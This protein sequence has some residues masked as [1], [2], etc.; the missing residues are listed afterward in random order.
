MQ[1]SRLVVIVMSV[2]AINSAFSHEQGVYNFLAPNKDVSLN[3]KDTAIAH[4]TE[5]NQQN[6]L[7]KRI[8]FASVDKPTLEI[9]NNSNWDLSQQQAISILVQNAMDW[10]VTLYVTITDIAGKQLQATV[11]LPAGPAQNLL[12]PLHSFSSRALGMREGLSSAWENNDHRYLL[13]TLVSGALASNKIKAISFS[14]D[15]PA[16][17]QYI[18]LGTVAAVNQDVERLAYTDI[19]DQYGQNTKLTWPEKVTTDE[20]L[21]QITAN[22][23]TQLK[24]TNEKS[25]LQDQYGGIGAKPQFK[26]THYFRTQKVGDHWYFVSPNGYIFYSFGVNTVIPDGSQ[27]YID[28]RDYMFASLPK[29]NSEL[30]KFYG[31]ANTSSGN[32]AQGGRGVDKGRWFDFY[33]AN[34]YRV[35]GNDYLQQ[36]MDSTV[37]RFKAWGFNTIG[38]WSNEALTQQH[39]LPYVASI[40]ITGDY[41]SVPSGM[42][43]WGFMP[44]TFDPKFVKA[45]DEAVKRATENKVNDSWL[46]GY[47]ADNEL[48]WGGVDGA[49]ASHYALA[50]NALAKDA[51]SPAKLAFLKQ[52]KEQYKTIENLNSAWGIKAK[53]WDILLAKGY[54]A[55]IPSS[56][57]PAIEQDYS[58]FLRA[59]ADNYFKTVHDALKTYDPNHL[60][61]GNRFAVKLPEVITSCAKYCDVISFNIYTLLA[62]EGYDKNLIKGLDKPIMITEFNFGAKTTGAFWGGPI[63]VPSEKA[64]GEG[65]KKFVL[66]AFNDPHM[67]GVHWFQYIDEPLTGRLLD[68]ENGHVGL[69]GITNVVYQTLVKEIEETN[70]Q[71]SDNALKTYSE[72]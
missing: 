67:V 20:Q 66:D 37:N 9:L 15:R 2:L 17:A 16:A 48:S 72:K 21:K 47:F 44:D 69:V 10:D 57:Y 39:K 19:V 51:K 3:S 65:Y 32:A 55:P 5:K 14:M 24:Q 71:V 60:F 46:I 25:L 11:A 35:Y 45:V 38:N 59:Y 31:N 68:G 34:L 22:E 56:A 62:S 12:V 40:N 58:H 26:A 28:G 6:I 33:R 36:W 64:R 18:L 54:K 50:I 23:L 53:S 41:D 29:D 70:K 7:L 63:T 52:L 13:P 1:L 4:E 27:T 42:D 8:S 49:P 30:S 43:W 61:L